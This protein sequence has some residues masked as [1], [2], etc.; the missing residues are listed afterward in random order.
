MDLSNQNCIGRHVSYK[1]SYSENGATYHRDVT[2]ECSHLIE[3]LPE[4]QKYKVMKGMGLKV[5][6]QNWILGDY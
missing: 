5:V 1:K 2:K 3:V 4:C 6:M